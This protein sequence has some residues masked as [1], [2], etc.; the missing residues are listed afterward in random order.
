MKKYIDIDSW[1]RKEHF[2][3]FKAF[4][5]PFFGLTVDVDFTEVH[6]KSKKEG[7]SF[8]LDSLYKIMQAVNDTE[9]FRYRIEGEQVTCYDAIHVS[10]TVGREDGTFGFSFWEFNANKSIFYQNARAAIDLVKKTEGLMLSDEMSRVDV[11]HY[12]PIPWIRFTDMK[13]A[14]SFSNASSVP[15]ITPGKLYC[16]E[17]GMKM[18]VSVT[19]NHAL[20]DG[21]HVAQFLNLLNK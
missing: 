18:A 1:N 14:M 4:D 15:K 6:N 17:G 12:S 3:F 10:S 8:F 21:F 16:D 19:T 2:R 20:M 11:I 13:H 9:A 5:D 7:G